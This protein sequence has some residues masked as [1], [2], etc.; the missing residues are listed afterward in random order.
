MKNEVS[1]KVYD[2]AVALAKA[3]EKA[4]AY[5]DSEDGGTCN[6]DCATIRLKG[7]RETDVKKACALA[8]GLYCSKWDGHYF[9]W[10]I[11]NT[12]GIGNRRTKMAEVFSDALKEQGYETSVWYAMD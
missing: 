10:H 11:D 9:N 1:K 3:S 2:L 6:F 12:S 4:N 5:I 8:G 7:W